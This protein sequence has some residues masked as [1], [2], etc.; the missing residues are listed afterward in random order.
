MKLKPANSYAL[1]ALMYMV[2]HATQLP[3]TV[4]AISK[5]ER[6]PYRQ[7]M[8]IFSRLAEAG[9]VK[10]DSSSK[11]GYVFARPPSGISLLELF[12][13]I[14][15]EPIFGEC[16]IKHCE[17]S[18]TPAE[19]KI[20]ASWKEATAAIAQKLSRISVENATWGHPEHYFNDVSEP[21]GP[22]T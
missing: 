21:N 20:Y 4:H 6:I 8:G 11:S 1:H 22:S 3:V 15:E 16:F 18:A 13:A 2:R 19:C 7:L 12:E 9:M 5:A 10:N 14:E 17:C